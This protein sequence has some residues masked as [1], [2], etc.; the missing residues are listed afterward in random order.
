MAGLQ[1]LPNG[2]TVMSN[3][4]GHGQFGKAPHLIEVTP[5]QEGRLD[6]RRSQDDEDHLQRPTPRRARRRHQRRNLA[7]IN[8]GGRASPRA[9]TSPG[10]WNNQGSRD[11]RQGCI[12]LP[13]IAGFAICPIAKWYPARAAQAPRRVSH[14]Q[15]TP[16]PVPSHIQATYSGVAPM[17][18]PSTWEQHRSNTRAGGLYRLGGGLRLGWRWPALRGRGHLKGCGTLNWHPGIRGA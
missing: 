18:M 17:L 5:R 12:K 1:R 8:S 14:F 2:N 7:L 10:C 13:I 11:A 6:L 3:W 15:A 9:Q 4:L 16:K